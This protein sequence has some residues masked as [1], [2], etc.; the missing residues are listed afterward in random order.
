MLMKTI[1][2]TWFCFFQEPLTSICIAM[3]I[4]T[5]QNRSK[6]LKAGNSYFGCQTE[7]TSE[8][9]AAKYVTQA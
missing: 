1:Y 2:Q 4:K 9:T 8:P 5:V 3:M 7:N 6:G